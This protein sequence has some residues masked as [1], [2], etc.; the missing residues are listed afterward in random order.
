MLSEAYESTGNELRNRILALITDHPEILE[1]DDCFKL[2]K[3][4]GFKCDD[5][6]PS[7]AQAGWAMRSAQ[8]LFRER[9][10][11]SA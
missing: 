3:V 9:Q 10:I 1:M 4:E 5:L 2:F 11:A 6:Q 8:R 7:L